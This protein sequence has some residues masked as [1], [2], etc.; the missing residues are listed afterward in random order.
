MQSVRTS[1]HSGL[2]LFVVVAMSFL[3][4]LDSSIVNIALPVMSRTLNVT[5]ASIEWVVAAYVMIIC[6][7]LLFFGRLGDSIGKVRVFQFGTVVFVA[8]TLLCG[9]CRSFVPLIVCRFIQGLGASAYMANNQGIVTQL[10]PREGRGRALGILASSVALG[11]MCGAPLGGLIVSALNWNYIFFV[12]VPVGTAV[13]LLGTKYLPSDRRDDGERKQRV[14]VPGCL[15]QFFGTTLLFCML[16]GAQQK[17]CD[18]KIL[19]G[20]C[21]LAVVLLVLFFVHESR[22]REPL[23]DLSLFSNGLYS[24]SLVCAFISFICIAAYTLVLPF[25]FEDTLRFAPSVSGILMVTAPLLI[26]CLSPVCGALSDRIGS[27]SLTA[28]GLLVMS[29]AFFCMSFFSGGTSVFHC[30]AVLACM[31]VGQA[32]F[33]PTNNSLIMAACPKTKLGIGGSVN[34]LVRNLG[35]YTGIVLSTTF[36][37]VFMS[38]RIGYRVTDYTK[39]RDDV[40]LYGMNRVFLIL[41]AVC[42]AGAVLTVLRAITMKAAKRTAER[43]TE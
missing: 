39:G 16:I 33:Q 30:A 23:L 5:L 1:R 41:T 24:V 34:S 40:F 38:R 13:F 31:A 42:A 4:T 15:L 26:A 21:A 18:Y 27:A 20:V 43:Q 6:S 37:Y 22:C 17:G 14:D 25:Y 2:T 8:G 10:Y 19:S 32:L 12:N 7:T 9:L 3:A 11:T 29:A 28:A 35:Q 36:L